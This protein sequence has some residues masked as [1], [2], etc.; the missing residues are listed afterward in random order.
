AGLLSLEGGITALSPE[1]VAS[2][3]PGAFDLAA[4]ASTE[5]ND[6]APWHDPAM[7]LAERMKLAEGRP[8]RRQMMAAMGQQDCGQCGY[9]CQDY[10]EAIVA[11]SEERLNLCVPGG[12]DTA[13][14]LKTL[15]AEIGAEAPAAK[16]PAEPAARL[17]LPAAP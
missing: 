9:N 11:K 4:P 13:R 2:L 1:Q 7:P 17:V 14:M 15:H 10:A 12:K 16:A 3:L 5:E 8:L 6:G